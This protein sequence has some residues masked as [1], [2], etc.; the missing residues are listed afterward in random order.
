MIRTLFPLSGWV[1]KCGSNIVWHG[2]YVYFS[3]TNNNRSFG[4]V[5]SLNFLMLAPTVPPTIFFHLF[6]SVA[7]KSGQNSP[8]FVQGAQVGLYFPIAEKNTSWSKC[9]KTVHARRAKSRRWS[10]SGCIIHRFGSWILRIWVSARLRP[11]ILFLCQKVRKTPFF[12][13]QTFQISMVPKFGISSKGAK[14][15]AFLGAK[16][17]RFGAF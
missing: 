11:V 10:G 7:D 9:T 5:Y 17:S 16:S 8:D 15:P 14:I 6:P 4:A 2:V 1:G 3:S 13:G 12:K